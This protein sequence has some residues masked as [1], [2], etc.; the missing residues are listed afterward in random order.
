MFECIFSKK[1]NIKLKI[2]NNLYILF[3]SLFPL[4]YLFK[5]YFHKNFIDSLQKI[6]NA[7]IYIFIYLYFNRLNNKY[8]TN[9]FKEKT[10]QFNLKI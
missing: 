10:H 5:F 7:N 6:S 2:N 9:S 8:N 4:I 1:I 3:E